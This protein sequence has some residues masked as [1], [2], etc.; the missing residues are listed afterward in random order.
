[1]DRNANP[2]GQTIWLASMFIMVFLLAGCSGARHVDGGQKAVKTT[3]VESSTDSRMPVIKMCWFQQ[4]LLRDAVAYLSQQ[5]QV[6]IV[7]SEDANAVRDMA[8]DTD[9]LSGRRL[10]E[11]LAAVLGY[12]NT[13][14]HET[15]RWK[16]L[17]DQT[18]IIW[19][20]RPDPAK[21]TG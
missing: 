11:V 4:S 9:D 7:L 18:I 12:L 2:H 21:P 15:F 17:P 14:Y 6:K 13:H 3:L 10:D 8:V 20:E 5:T 1:V 19:R 16:E